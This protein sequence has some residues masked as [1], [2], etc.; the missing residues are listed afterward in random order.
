MA[1]PGPPPSSAGQAHESKPVAATLEK[2]RL[3][4]GKGRPPGRPRK[5]AGD[6]GYCYPAVRAYLRRRG[7]LP[8]IPTRKD[9]RAN[10]RFDKATCRQRN[11]IEHCVGWLKENR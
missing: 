1:S 4:N 6:K 8:V 9:Q 7:I 5:L 2:V 3:P 10:P 11:V